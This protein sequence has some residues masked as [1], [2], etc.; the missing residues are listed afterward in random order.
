MSAVAVLVAGAGPVG[1]TMALELARFGVSVRVVDKGAMRTD[2]SKALAIWSRTLELLERSGAADAFVAAGRKISAVN[3]RAGHEEIAR[4][5]LDGPQTPYPFMLLIPQS[6]TERLLE[7]EL[8]TYGVSVERQT[9]LSDFAQDTGGITCHLAHPDGRKESVAAQWL[10]GCDGAHSFVR[11]ALGVSFDGETLATDFLLADVHVAGAGLPDDELSAF[12][13]EDGVAMFFPIEAGRFRLIADLGPAAAGRPEPTLAEAQALVDRRGPGGLT[14]ADPIWLTSFIINER[15]VSDYS[16]GRV[17]LA[18][19]AAHV[20][21]PAGGQGMNTGMQDAF[22]LAWKLAM[23]TSGRAAPEPL[24]SS[25]TPERGPVAADVLADSGRLTRIATTRNRVLQELRNFAAHHFLGLAA[26]RHALAERLS[27]VSVGYPKSPLNLKATHG[28]N[29]PAPG[30]RILAGAPY[31]KE[32]PPRFALLAADEAE[33]GAFA[34]DHAALVDPTIR[35]PPDPNGIWLVRP[36]GYVAAVAWR[37]EW[38][39]MNTYLKRLAG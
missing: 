38:T 30:A 36:D 28:L 22:N 11:H 2:K 32:S 35:T 37:G 31:G 10:I 16:V 3:L 9:E 26:T 6:E 19:D 23:V 12:W 39:C 7:A 13:H 14:L 24:L 29:G 34:R 4:V 33:A 1:L 18:G 25:Y 17:F 27:E 20:H 5:T 8:E 15:K 21:S